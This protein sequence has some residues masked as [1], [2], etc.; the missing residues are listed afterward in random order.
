MTFDTHQ[1]EKR[2]VR[3][4][5]TVVWVLANLTFLRDEAGRPLSWVGQFQDVT[6][7]RAL[8]ERDM[9]TQLYNRRRFGEA[10][11]ESLGHSARHQPTGIAGAVPRPGRAPRR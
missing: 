6:E 2:F 8:A 5:G 1:C 9:L 3:P 4:D 11:E 10:L 7:H